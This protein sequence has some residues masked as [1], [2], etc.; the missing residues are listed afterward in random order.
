MSPSCGATDTPVFGL[1]V[2]SPLGFKARVGSLICT[3]QRCI[4]YTFPEIHLWCDTFQPLGNQHGS[5]A[6]LFHIPVTRHWW[7][8]NRR[9]IA[10]QVNALPT[11]L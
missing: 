1:L 8:S 5:Q 6:D 10:K 11:E 3:W 2:M 4:C 7:G 9:P